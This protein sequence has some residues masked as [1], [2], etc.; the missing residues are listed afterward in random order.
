MNDALDRA[1]EAAG[2]QANL[3]GSIGVT[4]QAIT[5]WIRKGQVP[6]MRVLDV[7]RA[8]GVPRYEL[9][10]DIYPPENHAA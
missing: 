1:I 4:P 7:E 10:P 6:V 2:T 8:T 9:R 3:A 5:S